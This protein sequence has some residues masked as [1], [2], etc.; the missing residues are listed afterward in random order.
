MKM[1]LR[2]HNEIVLSRA[3]VSIL[4]FV[5]GGGLRTRVTSVTLMDWDDGLCSM[6]I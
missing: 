6:G 2:K 5:F 4:G 3:V 1:Q